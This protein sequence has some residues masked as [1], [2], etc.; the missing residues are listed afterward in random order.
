[1]GWK[2]LSAARRYR[3]SCGAKPSAS[4]RGRATVHTLGRNSSTIVASMGMLPPRPKPTK[5]T[6]AQMARQLS[7]APRIMP[8]GARASEDGRGTRV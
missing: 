1:M 4:K 7:S 2:T 8:G 3:R 5:K 6:T